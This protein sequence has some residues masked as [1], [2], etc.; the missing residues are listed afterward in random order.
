MNKIGDDM[1]D[2]IKKLNLPNLKHFILENN[3]FTNFE[4]FHAVEHFAKLELLDISSNPFEEN[5]DEIYS[6]FV[7][8]NLNSMKEI[9]LSNGVFNDNTNK[10]N[11]SI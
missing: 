7:F 11:L 2:C 10:I 3:N 6:E 9:N 1:I 4:F 8:Y 5:I